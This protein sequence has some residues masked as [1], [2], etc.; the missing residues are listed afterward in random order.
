MC[1]TVRVSRW[2]AWGLLP[3]IIKVQEWTYTV[4]QKTLASSSPAL[5]DVSWQHLENVP[6]RR[7]F[8]HKGRLRDEKMPIASAVS[9]ESTWDGGVGEYVDRG[10]FCWET[11]YEGGPLTKQW[12]SAC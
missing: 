11:M 4:E 7:T 1:I 10:I 6:S 12:R 8:G 5:V 2:Q 3:V 9:I